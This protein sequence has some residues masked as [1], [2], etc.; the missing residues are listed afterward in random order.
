V[1]CPWLS[2]PAALLVPAAYRSEAGSVVRAEIPR[3]FSEVFGHE[4]D[5]NRLLIEWL[6]AHAA[7]T[8]EI[9]INYEELPL[10][11]YLPNPIRGGIGAFRVS[12]DSKG[13][14]R[15]AILRPSVWFVFW[16]AF[17]H[18]MQRHQWEPLKVNIPDVVWG[19]N[20]D[21]AAH[22][23]DPPRPRSLFIARN[24][25]GQVATAEGR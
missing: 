9:L 1:V 22:V 7:P 14:P 2:K 5:P 6:E 3:L 8:D 17:K 10:V 15:F 16:P 12:D 25:D 13:A 4:P 23:T 18:E 24:V 21:P 20:P 19:N 11:F